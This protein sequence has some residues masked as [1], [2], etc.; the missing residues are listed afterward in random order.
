MEKSS[1]E[2]DRRLTFLANTVHEIRTPVQTI[3]GTL[4]LLSDTNLNNEQQEYV[5]QIQFSTNVLLSLVND[6]LDF[7]KIKSHQITLESIPYDVV[8]LTEQVVDLVSM[9]AFGKGI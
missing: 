7:T 6:I 4:E 3:I 5:R 9:E 2:G 1:T 8:D